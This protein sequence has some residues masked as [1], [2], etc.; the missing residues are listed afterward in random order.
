M[1]TLQTSGSGDQPLSQEVLKKLL[2]KQALS[3]LG[4]HLT[5]GELAMVVIEGLSGQAFIVTNRQRVLVFKRGV[6]GGVSFGRRMYSW[7]FNQICGIRI[8][9]R[10]LNGFAA[11][12]IIESDVDGMSYWGHG[13]NDV[14]KAAN[15]MPLD[16]SKEKPIREAAATL[17]KLLDVHHKHRQIPSI[18]DN[19]PTLSRVWDHRTVAT[20]MDNPSPLRQGENITNARFCFNCG[21]GLREAGKYCESCGQRLM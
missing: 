10:I 5:S 14:W 18:A 3:E 9:F 6:M 13:E 16:K 20:G 11:L 15:A 4:E 21:A 2:H 7:K 12:E 17:R 19:D 1:T 8:D